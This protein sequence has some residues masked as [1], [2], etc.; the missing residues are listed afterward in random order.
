MPT[1]ETAG[2]V[3]HFLKV[4]QMIDEFSQHYA[5]NY[6]P[7]WLNVFNEFMSSWLSKFCPGFPLKPHPFGNEY[8]LIANGDDGKPLMWCVKLIKGKDCPKK[9]NGSWA[10]P[11]ELLVVE[12]QGR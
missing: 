3:N 7:S 9:A 10:F 8:H 5:E 4:C 11:L 2:Y 6:H 12:F 1:V